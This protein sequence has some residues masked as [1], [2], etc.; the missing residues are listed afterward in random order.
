MQRI[1]NVAVLHVHTL[2]IATERKKN[3]FIHAC[4]TIYPRIGV[5]FTPTYR[6][7]RS[8]CFRRQLS[9]IIRGHL[10]RVIICLARNNFPRVETCKT[11]VSAVVG[12]KTTMWC[13]I[14]THRWPYALH[15]TRILYNRRFSSQTMCYFEVIVRISFLK[16]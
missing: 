10:A 4:T 11:I 7:I 3:D 8:Y 1:L 12:C 16:Y 15:N 6:I 5:L 14:I 9:V 13:S 2:N